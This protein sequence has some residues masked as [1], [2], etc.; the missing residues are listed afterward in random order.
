[1]VGRLCQVTP[2][3]AEDLHETPA[4]LEPIRIL[5]VGKYFPPHR[6]GMETF[7]RDLASVQARRGHKVHVLVH[8]SPPRLSDQNEKIV[9]TA[10]GCS[11]QVT[12]AARW[13]NVGFVPISPFFWATCWRLLKQRPHVIHLHLPNASALL[14]L[15]MPRARKIPWVIHWHSD[16]LTPIAP[17]WLRTVYY[18]YRPLEAWQLEHADA[19]VATSRAYADSSG[20][21]QT[22]HHKVEV[23]PLDVDRERLKPDPVLSKPAGAPFILAVGRLVPYKGFYQIIEALPDIP[24]CDLRVIGEGPEYGAL[25]TR[26]NQLGLEDR[27]TF[28]GNVSDGQLYAHYAACSVLCLPSIDRTEAFGLAVLEA[29]HFDCPVVVS[30]LAGSGLVDAARSARRHETFEVGNIRGLTAVLNNVLQ[31]QSVAEDGPTKS[32]TDGNVASSPEPP[33]SDYFDQIDRLYRE[34]M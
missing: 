4:D 18:F 15:L 28:L 24:G 2:V 19:I 27:V 25:E 10:S 20:P 14:L 16:V 21:L 13:F 17:N 6:G 3:S 22:F 12:R 9:D 11:Y 26:A 23:I 8:S 31:N 32:N 1:M 30:R 5:H 34:L 29:Q 33:I 7:A